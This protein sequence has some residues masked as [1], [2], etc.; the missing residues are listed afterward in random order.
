MNRFLESK[1]ARFDQ[2]PSGLG[3]GLVPKAKRLLRCVD[4]RADILATPLRAKTPHFIYDN[5]D[6]S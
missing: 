3:A 4:R 6:I 2:L 5:T 1:V